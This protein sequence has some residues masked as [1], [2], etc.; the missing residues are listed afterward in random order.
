MG[1]TPWCRRSSR[2]GFPCY[3]RHCPSFP[4]PAQA[5]NR[6]VETVRID[7]DD[8]TRLKYFGDLNFS[9]NISAARVVMRL[10]A[11]TKAEAL[12]EL[13]ELAAQSPKVKNK[14]EFHKRVLEREEI[15]N[16]GIGNGIAIPHART[17]A[18]DDVV[19][20]LGISPEGIDYDSMDGKPARI[21]ILFGVNEKAHELYLKTL[22][23]RRGAVQAHRFR[24]RASGVR[25]HKPSHPADP[26]A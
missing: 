19:V 20:T 23:K 24:G 16:T 5:V 9:S 11:K 1:R 10:A 2:L 15:N 12:R 3:P 13:V 7:R 25:R 4:V 8:L 17:D 18:V 6:E 14:E 21:I 22:G 26:G